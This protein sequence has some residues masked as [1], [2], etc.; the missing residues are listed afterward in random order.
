LE[1]E[2]RERQAKRIAERQV[3]AEP[4]GLAAPPPSTKR[5]IKRKRTAL[6]QA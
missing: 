3:A 5:P 2:Q 1:E 6:K 4:P